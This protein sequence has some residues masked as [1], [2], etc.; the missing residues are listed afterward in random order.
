M[1][2]HIRDRLALGSNVMLSG[3]VEKM[4]EEEK[5]KNPEENTSQ[6]PSDSELFVGQVREQLSEQDIF[7]GDEDFYKSLAA[8]ATTSSAKP[9]ATT[10]KIAKAIRI[11][12]PPI[13]HKRFSILQIALTAGIIIIGS[14]LLY[15]LLQSPSQPVIHVAAEPKTAIQQQPVTAQPSITSQTVVPT[16]PKVVLPPTQP[17]SLKIAEEFFLKQEYD[18]AYAVYEMLDHR[19]LESELMSDFFKLKMGFSAKNSGNTEQA[20]QLFREVLQSRSPIIRVIANYNR[21]FDEIR[22][23]QYLKARTTAYKTIALIDAVGFD[24]DWAFNVARNCNLLIAK[25]LT[26]ESLLLYDADKDIPKELWVNEQ[27]VIDPLIHLTERNLKYLLNYGTELLAKGSLSPQIEK[28]NSA[29]STRWSV[30]CNG[31]SIEELMTD[32]AANAGLDIYWSFGQNADSWNYKKRPTALYMPNVTINQFV[33][34]AA[35]S[36]GLLARIDENKT[37]TILDTKNYA[38]LSNHRSLLTQQAISL[39]QKFQLIYHNDNYIPNA[40]FALAL[41]Q[42]KRGQL[43]NAIDEYKLIANRFPKTSLA[44]F[45]LL[46]SSKLKISIKDYMGARQDLKNLV[47]LYPDSKVS[48]IGGLYLADATMKSKLYKEAT[49]LY[50]KVYHLG[51]SQKLQIS[52]ALGA[53]K[54]LFCEGKDYKSTEKWLIR[55]INSETDRTAKDLYSAYILLG[56]T[57]LMQENHQKACDAFQYALEGRLNRNDYVETIFALVE[58][59][60]KLKN[61]IKALDILES[62]HSWQLSQESLK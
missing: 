23:K 61:F 38:S 40:H 14:V 58:G 59:N 22:K 47:E 13:Q 3:K 31:A 9:F 54:S 46:H 16:Q 7:A 12:L 24:M 52:A 19:L 44:P 1:R 53:G 18:K 49:R 55:Y 39:W 6:I 25:S 10:Q 11:P 36:V 57:Y 4:A 60:L 17:I 35:G 42:A 45:A 28:S 41:L 56:K 29:D 50:S 48:S 30:I 51:L 2:P 5:Q 32:F 15:A 37:I 8:S 34:T 26:K 33:E 27:V 62:I 21:S 20:T 43:T